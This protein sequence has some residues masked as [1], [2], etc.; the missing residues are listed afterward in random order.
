MA[1]WALEVMKKL[2]SRMGDFFRD[3]LSEPAE[4]EE[5]KVEFERLQRIFLMACDEAEGKVG[6]QQLGQ[7]P[8]ESIDAPSKGTDRLKMLR[9]IL[10]DVQIKL[11][12]EDE[13]PNVEI[14]AHRIANLLDDLLRFGKT[15]ALVFVH[16][17]KGREGRITSHLLDPGLVSGPVLKNCAGSILMSGTLYPP[18]MYADLLGIGKEKTTKQAY[19]SPFA[20]ERRPIMVANDVTTRYKDRSY[21][22]TE[23]IRNHLQALCDGTP[24]HVAVFVP[25]YS[26]LKEYVGAVSYTHL[27]AHET[28]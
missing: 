12:T 28:R 19:E 17:T 6:Q 14:D 25:S 11:E 13:N 9:D 16:D 3:I 18:K 26:M 27:R 20:K 8:V 24:G 4:F 15:T 2:R 22:N 21:D 7:E 10:F 23:R 1:S 5:R